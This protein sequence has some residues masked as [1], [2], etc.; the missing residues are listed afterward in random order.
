VVYLQVYAHKETCSEELLV[1]RLVRRGLEQV[2]I[3]QGGASS[4]QNKPLNPK[5]QLIWGATMY[6]IDDL[7]FP[8]SNLPDVYTQFRKVGT[9]FILTALYIVS[10]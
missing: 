7:P 2:V 9:P 5:L 3:P 4:S 6:H 8:V 1:E 10:F